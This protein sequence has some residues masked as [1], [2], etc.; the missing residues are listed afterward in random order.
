MTRV[1]PCSCVF[2]LPS[3]YWL[4]GKFGC[5]FPANPHVLNA[6]GNWWLVPLHPAVPGAREQGCG[7]TAR[8]R[9]AGPAAG[10]VR[11]QG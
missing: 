4:R 7:G 2:V 3:K 1:L 6:L 8:Q 11:N 5:G 9:R 10:F